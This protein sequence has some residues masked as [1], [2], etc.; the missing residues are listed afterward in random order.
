MA[1]NIETTPD[2]SKTILIRYAELNKSMDQLKTANN[3]Y[4]ESERLKQIAKDEKEK[5]ELLV[6]DTLSNIENSLNGLMKQYNDYIYSGT[7]TSPRI[8]LIDSSHYNFYTPND[9]GTGSLLRSL[10]TFD[11]AMLKLTSLPAVIHDTVIL[12]HIDDGTLEKI[13]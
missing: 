5:Y 8:E 4:L 12:K 3:N 10:V 9:T 2:V 11:L 13:N 6:K 1:K 7:K